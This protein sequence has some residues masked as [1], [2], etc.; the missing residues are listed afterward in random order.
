MDILFVHPNMPGQYKH[1]AR[2]LGETGAHRIYFLTKHKTAEIPGVVRVT[3]AM[4][5][6]PADAKPHRYLVPMEAA[7]RQG[8]QVW[9]VLYDLSRREN[10]TP[11]V[12]V[13]HPGW[14]DMLF[15]KDLFPKARVLSFCEFY[16]RATGADV[17]FDPADPA[18]EDDAPR[19]RVKNAVNLLNLEQM[20]WGISPTS[21]QWSLH[22]PEFQGKLAM[23]H[24]GIDTRACQPDA[25]ALLTLP[26]GKQFKKG[27]EVVTYIAR[28][29]E[30]YRGF[31]TFMKVAERLLAERPNLHIIAVGADSVSYGKR[32]PQGST[33]RDLLMKEVNLPDDRIHFTGSLPYAELLKV[34]QVSKAHLY[35]TYPFVL[36][37]GMM[38]A[39]ACGVALVASNT[40]PVREVVQDG[41]NGLMAD[42]FAPD[43]V[44][45]KLGQL[46]DASDD[47][48][49]MRAAARQT[50]TERYAL[51]RLLP[52]Q[53]RLVEE[54]AR[55]QLPPPV[56]QE[57]QRAQPLVPAALWQ[58]DR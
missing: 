4:P 32:A 48:A 22:P 18:T 25:S 9:R 13:G 5:K 27:D 47:N 40:V 54:V 20:D 36:S 7:I 16:Y 1:L 41:I 8:Q 52:L 42:F 24:D 38:E 21:W 35:L 28:N 57:I 29:F 45:A 23:L 17:A 30:P 19:V 34:F 11:Q 55:G 3:Y 44:A 33:Y 58:A 12:I 49:A 46:L 14:G 43:D 53:V 39:M 31:P 6:T 50:I 15:V 51:E 10:F 37:W 2:A 26:N 56:M